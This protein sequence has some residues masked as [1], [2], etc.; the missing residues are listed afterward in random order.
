MKLSSINAHLSSS[1]TSNTALVEETW[2]EF[3]SKNSLPLAMFFFFVQQGCVG[4]GALDIDSKQGD[5]KYRFVICPYN[6]FYLHVNSLD[7]SHDRC[8]MSHCQYKTALAKIQRKYFHQLFLSKL[9]KWTATKNCVQ[10]K[11]LTKSYS[12]FYPWL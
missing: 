12:Y 3:V 1:P 7:G 10:D 5:S 9:N 2:V 8:H 11:S 4:V 6:T